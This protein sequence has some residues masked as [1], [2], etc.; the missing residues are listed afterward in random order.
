VTGELPHLLPTG[1]GND[2]RRDG[3]SHWLRPG[4]RWGSR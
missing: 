2:E 1:I 4:R 3:N